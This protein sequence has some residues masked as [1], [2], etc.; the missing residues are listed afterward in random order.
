[1]ER[2]FS[3]NMF[4]SRMIDIWAALETYFDGLYYGDVETLRSV[5]H[6]KA[7]YASPAS[8]PL[9]IKTM[10]EYFELVAKREPP[11]DRK[12][13]RV[14]EVVSLDF[15]GSKMVFARVRCAIGEKH[16]TDFLTLILVDGRWQILSKVFDY[17]YRNSKKTGNP[18]LG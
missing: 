15:A 9:L 2:N 7:T 16:F 3:D 1:M 8:G 10:P 12:E 14:D 18:A 5:F 4:P 13:D 6:P 17:T 11:S